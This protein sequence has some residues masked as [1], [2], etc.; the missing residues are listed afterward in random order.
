MVKGVIGEETRFQSVE[1]RLTKSSPPAEVG[2]LIGKFSS[3]LDRVFLFDLIPTPPNDS[4]EPASSIIQADKKPASKSKS[5]TQPDSSS[6]FI[7]KDWVSEHARQVSRMLVGGIKVVGVY[8]WVN[9]NAFKNSTLM[10]CQVV[11]INV[12]KFQL[13]CSFSS[14]DMINDFRV[15]YGISHWH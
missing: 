13:T 12:T 4:A 10:L 3:A 14:I 9:D 15:G 8:V 11:Y 6:L 5:Q 7:D 2:L 1:D